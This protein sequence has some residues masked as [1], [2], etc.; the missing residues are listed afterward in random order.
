M[1]MSPSNFSRSFKDMVGKG[2]KEYVDELRLLKAREL[3]GRDEL[4]IEEIA[5]RVGYENITSFY[6]FFKKQ[7]GVAPGVYRDAARQAN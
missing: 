7:T 2:F 1:G 6:R 3:L 4:S 5:Q